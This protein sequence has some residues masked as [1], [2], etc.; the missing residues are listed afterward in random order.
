MNTPEPSPKRSTSE[1]TEP[2]LDSL[3]NQQMMDFTSALD[4][5]MDEEVVDEHGEA[6]GTLACYWHS[7][8]GKLIFLGIKIDGHKGVRVVPGRRSQMDDQH[9]CI[10]LGFAA[11]DIKSAPHFD[12]AIEVDAALERAVYDHFA[13][14][15]GEPHGGLRYIG[16]QP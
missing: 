13:I 12:C 16:R 5:F 4:D 9:A 14:D 1:P 6:V 10:K 7:V 11:A 3:T 8:S 2:G 15:E